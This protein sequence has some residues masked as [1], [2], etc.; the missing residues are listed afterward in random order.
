MRA[1]TLA[2][3]ACRLPVGSA[4]LAAARRGAV[5]AGGLGWLLAAMLATGC[6]S[7]KRMTY[8]YTPG[9]GVESDQFL[10]SL[11]GLRSE[12][13]PGNHVTL[14]ENGDAIFPSVL[15]AIRG[16]QQ[17]I[18]LEMYIFE[19][20]WT[21]RE[22][23]DALSE[24]ARAG[25]QVRV[26]VDDFGA[27]LGRLAE[28]MT[29]AGV[30]FQ[31]YKPLRLYSLYRLNHRT[32]RKI[33]TVDGRIAFCGGFGIDDRWGGDARN[34]TEWHDLV[35]RVE[36]PVVAHVQ[37][38]FM[39][40]WL[41]T[42]GEV[43]FGD[44]QFPPLPPVGDMLAQAVASSRTDQSSMAKLMLFMA[45]QTARKSI[46]IEN[47][48]FVPDPQIRRGLLAAVRRG[49]DVRVIVP[50]KYMDIPL[51]RRASRY[52]YGELLD[53]GVK[54]YEYR[55]T[56]LHAKAMV[57]D[58]IWS[59]VGSINFVNRSMRSNAEANIAI[60]DRR[61]AGELR[62]V[63]EHDMARSE[64]FTKESWKKRGLASRLSEA[65]GWLF[66]EAY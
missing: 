37:R 60:Y 55:P 53:G 21:G 52:R 40:D 47:A 35:V 9:Y 36:G 39:E 44:A 49:V 10:R 15:D 27:R 23:A 16:A 56:M 50:G 43:L 38:I 12:M 1:L 7:G 30:R 63:M 25:V 32:H 57:V 41:H 29:A 18:N 24:R 4:V 17:S 13:K 22:F 31:I 14:L 3:S 61:F 20:D 33:I 64:V 11:E 51:I 65:F 46:W 8:S 5:S 54:I 66:S 6:L 42:T 59:T 58:D 45:I 48:Y 34:P 28:V 62:Q 26:L 19:D 2:A